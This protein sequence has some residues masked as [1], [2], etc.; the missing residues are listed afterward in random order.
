[1]RSVI[2]D[3]DQTLTQNSLYLALYKG[4]LP[5]SWKDLSKDRLLNDAKFLVWIFGGE[6]RLA[7]L[8]TFLS[9]L[10][11]EGVELAISTLSD[12][13]DVLK[14]FRT[15]QQYF[16]VKRKQ[17]F[18]RW[19]HA[20]IH[21][22]TEARGVWRITTMDVMM[23]SDFFGNPQTKVNF[24][25]SYK[26]HYPGTVVFVDD[27]GEASGDYADAEKLGVLTIAMPKDGGIGVVEMT[28]IE[29]ALASEELCV[30][31]SRTATQLRR[32]KTFCEIH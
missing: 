32:G 31:C 16:L 11:S 17:L 2:F 19:I 25:K 28:K 4:K 1:M 12:V 14:A 10:Y 9:R 5:E 3:F 29:A 6:E 26:L 20:R 24:I 23:E 22:T 8:S 7:G 21:S 27:K 15:L 13:N 18:F 30:I